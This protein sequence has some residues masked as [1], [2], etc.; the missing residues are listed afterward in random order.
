MAKNEI[1]NA[2]LTDEIYGNSRNN[3]NKL[4]RQNKR[5]RTQNGRNR[6]ISTEIDVVHD[7]EKLTKLTKIDRNPQK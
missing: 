2:K 5:Y 6:L 4:S 3:Q 1:R 7:I